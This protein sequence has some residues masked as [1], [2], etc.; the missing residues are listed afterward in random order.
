MQSA[1]RI[2][3]WAGPLSL[4]MAAVAIADTNCGSATAMDKSGAE[5][6]LLG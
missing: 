5:A 2:C 3:L 1:Q 6:I 4:L